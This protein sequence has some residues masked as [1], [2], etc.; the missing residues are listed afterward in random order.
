MR[1]PIWKST[2][3]FATGPNDE[4]RIDMKVEAIE[5]PDREIQVYGKFFSDLPP[6]GHI[7]DIKI[8]DGDLTGE[9][10]WFNQNYDDMLGKDKVVRLGGHYDNTVVGN[11]GDGNRCTSARLTSVALVPINDMPGYPKETT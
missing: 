11:T 1:H 4:G 5:V 6:L 7:T 3:F 2:D 9:V 10:T 8:E